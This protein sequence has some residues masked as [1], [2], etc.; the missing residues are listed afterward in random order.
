MLCISL[1]TS[2]PGLVNDQDLGSRVAYGRDWPAICIEELIS[3]TQLCSSGLRGTNP[4]IVYFILHLLLH[5]APGHYF[6]V[7]VTE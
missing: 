1:Y 5:N 3:V 6:G 4:H 7:T 2:A